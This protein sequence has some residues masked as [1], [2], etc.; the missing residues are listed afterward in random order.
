M[1]WKGVTIMDQRIRFMLSGGSD[2]GKYL[3]VVAERPKNDSDL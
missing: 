2:Q 3:I 1:G